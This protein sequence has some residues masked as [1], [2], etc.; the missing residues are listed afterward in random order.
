MSLGLSLF[1]IC[2]IFTAG[3]F[4]TTTPHRSVQKSLAILAHSEPTKLYTCVY[5]QTKLICCH[6]YT[7]TE[8]FRINCLHL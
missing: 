4:I 3:Q 7:T 1:K 2:L 6:L 5:R 8:T